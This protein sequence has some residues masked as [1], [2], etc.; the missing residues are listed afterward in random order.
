LM[1]NTRGNWES[2]DGRVSRDD[3]STRLEANF[4]G[5][6]YRDAWYAHAG[7]NYLLKLGHHNAF[8]ELYE[9]GKIGVDNM[10]TWMA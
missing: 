9:G 7:R 2:A 3:A 10:R 8:R 1:L 4:A 5:A 6:L